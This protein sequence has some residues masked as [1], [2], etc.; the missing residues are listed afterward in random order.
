MNRTVFIII[1]AAA[2]FLFFAGNFPEKILNYCEAKLDIKDKYTYD[3]NYLYQVRKDQHMSYKIQADIVML[4]D[5]MTE[6]AE[7]NELLGRNDVV[8]RGIRGD[9]TEGMLN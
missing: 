5:S 3:K 2:L 1:S 7:W 8:N 4:G 9:I 6:F